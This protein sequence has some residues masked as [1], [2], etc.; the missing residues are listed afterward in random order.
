V[1]ARVR[2]GH[3]A[4]L[5]SLAEQDAIGRS[6]HIVHEKGVNF[7]E[8]ASRLGEPPSASGRA[9]GLPARRFAHVLVERRGHVLEVTLNRPEAMN[10]LFSAAHFELHESGMISSAI[11]T[12]GSRSS[13]GRATG[14]FA[15]AMT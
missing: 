11:L 10:A 15:A 14:P 2:T 12:C 9:A 13:R 5:A 7:V 3:R 8:P 6:V 4:T 1:L